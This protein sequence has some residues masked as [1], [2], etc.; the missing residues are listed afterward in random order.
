MTDSMLLL[1]SLLLSSTGSTGAGAASGT[2]F[3]GGAAAAG[4]ANVDSITAAANNAVLARRNV[5]LP[6]G[7]PM[8]TTPPGAGIEPP[9]SPTTLG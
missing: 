3:A 7:D 9:P 1:V 2:G 6:R 5:C 8:I 4:N